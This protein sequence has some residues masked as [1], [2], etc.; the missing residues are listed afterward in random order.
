MCA[1]ARS[2]GVLRWDAGRDHVFAFELAECCEFIRGGAEPAVGAA[3]G[4]PRVCI[5]LQLVPESQQSRLLLQPG[6]DARSG[7]A[8]RAKKHGRAQATACSF[9][10]NWVFFK[11][12]QNSL[13][14][15]PNSMP[16]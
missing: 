16:I 14:K 5:A 10:G 7:R 12:C 4:L 15:I 9:S 13:K 2:V 1:A 6:L 11:L 3:V 8:A